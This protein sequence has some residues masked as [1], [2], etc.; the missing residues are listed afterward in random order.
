MVLLDAYG[1]IAVVA[2]DSAANEVAD[3]LRAGD[4]GVLSVNL[5]EAFDVLERVYRAPSE[6]VDEAIGALLASETIRPVSVTFEIARKA[7]KLRAR[8]YDASQAAL[9]IADCFLL[10]AATADDTIATPDQPI[11]A[12]AS[13]EG[14][15]IH[16]LPNSEGVRPRT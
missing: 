15:A 12:V 8:H 14:I 6:K 10:A 4:V 7:G 5:A 13:R 16:P 11:A 2:G 9:S 1:V 3:L